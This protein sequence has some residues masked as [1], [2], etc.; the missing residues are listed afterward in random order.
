MRILRGL[1]GLIALV[2][3]GGV[4]VTLILGGAGVISFA[5]IT[6]YL[7]RVP[8]T[9]FLILIGVVLV[10]SAVRFLIA[11]ARE[12]E[13][14]GVFSRESEGGEIALT[15]FA[16]R[17]FIRGI[18]RDELGLDQ[19]RVGLERREDG[20]AI[21]VKIALSHEQSVTEVGQRIQSV[22]AREVPGRT[23][24]GVAGVSILVRGIRALGKSRPT[25][26]V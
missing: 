8:G 11:S 10:L 25:G 23:G 17:E 9:I 4:G 2:V 3:T 14:T 13:S 6:P 19:F 24:V 1:A 20:V 26:E 12:R 22:L 16:V 5:S 18:L 21:T 15:S 7:D